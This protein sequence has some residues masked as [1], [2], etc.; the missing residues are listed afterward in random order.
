MKHFKI[1][2]GLYKSFQFVTNYSVMHGATEIKP[3][4]DKEDPFACAKRLGKFQTIDSGNDMNTEII[5]GRI[6]KNR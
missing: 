4:Q 5:I 1:D 2:L 3:N 6:I